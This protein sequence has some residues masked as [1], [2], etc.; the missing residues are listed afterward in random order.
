MMMLAELVWWAKDR[1]AMYALYQ[2]WISLPIIA[3]RKKH[4]E[5]HSEQ[6]TVTRNAKSLQHAESG[7]WCLNATRGKRQRRK[8]H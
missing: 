1:M 8:R 2:M 5:S 3:H 7:S 4:S 6:A